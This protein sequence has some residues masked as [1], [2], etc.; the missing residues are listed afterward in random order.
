[1]QIPS[2][3]DRFDKN[4]T[5]PAENNKNVMILQNGPLTNLKKPPIQNKLPTG[6]AGLKSLPNPG[7]SKKA[8]PAF[9]KKG[10][11]CN[12]TEIKEKDSAHEQ[13]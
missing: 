2:F 6:L 5:E 9:V 3:K 13:S 12:L 1:M 4:T 11:K 8:K 7:I 10:D